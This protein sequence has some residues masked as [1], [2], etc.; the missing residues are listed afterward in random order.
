MSW[1]SESV[2]VLVCEDGLLVV[3]PAHVRRLRHCCTVTVS[4]AAACRARE[5]T[6]EAEERT[7]SPVTDSKKLASVHDDGLP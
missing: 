4:G 1:I 2:K 5:S 6:R 7:R 3:P